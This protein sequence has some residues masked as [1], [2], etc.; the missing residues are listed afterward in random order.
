MMK[1]RWRILDRA[2]E[3]SVENKTQIVWALIILHNMIIRSGDESGD[4]DVTFTE[5][6][7]EVVHLD[8]AY[9]RG[10]HRREL[11]VQQLWLDSMQAPN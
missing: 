1:K 10:F 11:L 2:C 6:G 3:C 9:M 4:D 8:D 7:K 5:G